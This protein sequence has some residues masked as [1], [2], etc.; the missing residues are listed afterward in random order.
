MKPFTVGIITGMASL[1][2]AVPLLAGV[3]GAQANKTT[4]ATRPVPSQACAV[5]MADVEDVRLRTMDQMITVQ[6]EAIQQ[7]ATALR[8]AAALTDDTARAEAL[9]KLHADMRKQKESRESEELTTAMDAMHTDCGDAAWGFGMKND[10]GEGRG[11]G[12][13]GA[14]T[15]HNA[16]L[17]KVGL[18]EDELQTMLNEGKTLRDIAEEREIEL[19]ERGMGNS[20]GKRGEMMRG[21][22]MDLDNDEALQ[23]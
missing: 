19:P 2:V 11:R 6:K 5:A 20:E 8:A 12:M 13:T 4:T 22:M 7:R 9:Q 21:E 18:S 14:G 15:M 23:Q 1:A 3:A 10:M 16:L 17:E